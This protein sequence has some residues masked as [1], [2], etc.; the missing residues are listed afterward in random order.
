MIKG[1]WPVAGNAFRNVE[2]NVSDS[3]DGIE[4]DFNKTRPG[5]F[6]RRLVMA[7]VVFVAALWCVDALR[8]AGV[9]ADEAA[10]SGWSQPIDVNMAD[11]TSLMLLPGVGPVRAAAIVQ[12]RRTGGAFSDLDDLD[13]VTGMSRNVIDGL[14]PFARAGR[15]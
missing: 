11:E 14:R 1:L 8:M 10:L 4:S 9:P 7:G 15:L 6:A 2:G 3:S 13:R 12:A 5:G